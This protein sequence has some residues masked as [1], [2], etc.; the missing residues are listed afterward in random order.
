M[1]SRYDLASFRAAPPGPVAA[2]IPVAFAPRRRRDDLRMVREGYCAAVLV[3]AAI[4]LLFFFP[5]EHNLLAT[6]IALASSIFGISYSLD[7]E[8][9]RQHPI[10]ALI[11]MMFTTTSTSGALLVK[12]LEWSP[13]VDRLEVPMITFPVLLVAQLTLIVADRLY[14]RFRPLGR[15]RNFISVRLVQPLGLLRWP[16]DRDL[17]VLGALGCVSVLLT[18]TDFESGASFGLA[19]AGDKLIRAFGF[20]KF[21]PF[22]I[23]FR[24]GLSGVPSRPRAPLLALGLFFIGLVVIS[25]ATNSR[26]TF[27]DAVP[28]LGLCVLIATGLGRSQLRRVPMGKLVLFGVLAAVAGILLSRVAL[29]MVV[30][31]DYRNNADVGM[32]VKMTLEAL[33]NDEWLQAAKAKMDTATTVGNYSEDYVNSRFLARF[34]LTKFHDNILYYFSLMGP[35][36]VASYKG[37]MFDRL[38]ATLPDP[39]LRPLGIN[40]EKAD[41]I[42]SNGDYIIYLV[43]GWGL[44]GFKTGS[45]IGEIF[46]VYGW[47]FPLLMVG[48]ALLLFVVYDAFA[49]PTFDGRLAFSPLMLLLIWNL[50]GTTAAFGFGTESVTAIPSGIVRGMPQNVLVY[51]I[52]IHLVRGASRL[53]GSRR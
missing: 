42:V 24:D 27:A 9:F 33:F 15:I 17:W 10:S 44:G 20:L 53:L 14:L 51:L 13:L 32:L 35:D 30:V 7:S 25:F 1:N 18:G 45:M 21:A 26:S 19:S 34:L 50:V 28:T 37:F 52:A 22:L 43:D 47:W 38:A 41:M 5:V 3:A 31:R 6:I 36:H 49:P 29:A 40:V 4:Q 12:G 48:C 23:P 39:L 46:G 8:R 2:P 11:L 16:S